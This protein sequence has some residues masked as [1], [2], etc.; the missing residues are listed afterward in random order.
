MRGV[1][2]QTWN[3]AVALTGHFYEVGRLGAWGAV[4]AFLGF[5]VSC[6][7]VWACVRGSVLGWSGV[8]RGPGTA[9]SGMAACHWWGC[10]SVYSWVRLVESG[11]LCCL[12]AL[13]DIPSLCMWEGSNVLVPLAVSVVCCPGPCRA[14]PGPVTGPGGPSDLAGQGLAVVASAFLAGVAL[15]GRLGESRWQ[16]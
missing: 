13:G 2:F 14:V 6:V 12:G 7:F 15:L 3:C 5:G 16:S 8:W 1:R 10:V 11:V 4:V 9:W